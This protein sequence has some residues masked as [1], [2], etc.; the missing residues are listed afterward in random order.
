MKSVA[1]RNPGFTQEEEMGRKSIVV[2]GSVNLDFVCSAP[3]IP[4]PGETITGSSFATFQGGKG[5]NQAVAVA[6][7][8]Y[9]VA[10]IAKVSPDEFG[11]RLRNGLAAAGVK[12]A[13]VT[14]S[15]T[16]SCGVALITTDAAGNNSIVVVPGANGDLLPH[17]LTRHSAL[18][19]SAGIVLVQLETPLATVRALAEMT[20]RHGVPL[21]LD[22]AP[23]RKLPRE[24]LRSV[25][26]LTPNE[27]ETAILCGTRTACSDADSAERMARALRKLGPRHIV[28]KMGDK[29]A[30]ALDA[31][32]QCHAVPAFS[33]KAVD[34]TAA[35]DAFN[36]GFAVGLM[37][38]LPLPQAM[39]FASAVAAISVT[40][41]GA[42][43]SMPTRRE[44]TAFLRRHGATVFRQTDGWPQ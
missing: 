4:A 37:E 19:H 6:R 32:G 36:G 24:I 29:G 23:A 2:V 9:P 25:T 31:E 16:A 20:S 7:L 14:A 38:G 15:K 43:P 18:I 35:G 39:R 13:S 10:M 8:G 26:Y 12:V 11:A 33:V 27:S 40:H 1:R 42:Q 21:M 17:D 34:S 22:P 44:V 5:A 28:L 3:R 41:K 30:F